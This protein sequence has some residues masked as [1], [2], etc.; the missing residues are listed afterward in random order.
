[1]VDEGSHLTEQGEARGILSRCV[2]VFG[3]RGGLQ[4][5]GVLEVLDNSRGE[6]EQVY[7]E[8]RYLW[9]DLEGGPDRILG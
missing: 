2:I 9:V 4:E 7:L 1:V 8:E 6:L 3:R 5:R